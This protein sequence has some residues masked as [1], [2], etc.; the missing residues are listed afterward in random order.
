MFSCCYERES[1]RKRSFVFEGGRMLLTFEITE[2]REIF[3]KF[4]GAERKWYPKTQSHVLTEYSN[5]RRQSTAH[6]YIKIKDS[7]IA[8]FVMLYSHQIPRSKAAV[9]ELS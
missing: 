4:L 8:V 5:K 7:T 3:E 9:Y 6:N 2:C 1:G